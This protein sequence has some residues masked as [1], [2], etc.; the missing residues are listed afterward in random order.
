MMTAQ[1]SLPNNSTTARFLAVSSDFSGNVLRRPPRT[2]IYD[3]ETN[4]VRALVQSQAPNITNEELR[5][6]TMKQNTTSG[7]ET[8]HPDNTTNPCKYMYKWQTEDFSTCNPIHEVDMTNKVVNGMLTFLACGGD[9]C[10]FRVNNG[11]MS[12][13]LKIRHP[14]GDTYSEESYKRTKKD[15]LTMERLTKSPYILNMYGNCALSQLLEYADGGTLYDLI[16]RT[17]AQR[18]MT[19]NELLSPID[20]LRVA[21]QIITAVADLHSTDGE[22]VASVTHN[23]LDSDQFLLVD[24]VFKLNDF[25]LSYFLQRNEETGNVCWRRRAT[26]GRNSKNHAPEESNYTRINNEKADDY[27]A[28]NIIYYILTNQWVFE[29]V[30]NTESIKR[31]VQG[32]RSPFPDHILNSINPADQAIM[33]GIRDLWTHDVEKRPSARTVSNFFIKEL[34]KITESRP[35]DGVARV[36]IPPLPD[37]WDYGG[38]GSSFDDNL[39]D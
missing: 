7:I 14:Y 4:I 30:K 10:T 33:K 21:I 35:A 27:T 36:S 11:S 5:L 37:D 19:N 25:Y 24:G 39:L 32:F 12:L 17:R 2:I 8:S 34:E 18:K 23:D 26:L 28:G 1:V 6:A 13:A 3:F 20:K 22:S 29:G 15:Y 16:R 38:G 9:R 31:L